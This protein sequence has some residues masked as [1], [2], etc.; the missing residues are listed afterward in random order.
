MEK[1]E[2]TCQRRHKKTTLTHKHKIEQTECAIKSNF[3]QR[4][5]RVTKVRISDS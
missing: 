2:L 5:S 4:N 3:K 1:V